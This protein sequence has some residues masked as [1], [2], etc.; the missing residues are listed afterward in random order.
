MARTDDM[1]DIKSTVESLEPLARAAS[2]RAYSPYSKVRVGAAVVAADDQ[3]FTGCNV[4]NASYG[5]TQ[6]AERN[7][8]VSAVVSGAEPGTIKTIVIYSNGFESLS[9][10]GACRQVM[11]ELMTEDALVISCSDGEEAHSWKIRQLIPDPF[12]LK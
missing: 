8:L 2:E 1:P 3:V 5:L 9:P 7:A 10:C 11:A 12:E 6:C 4:E